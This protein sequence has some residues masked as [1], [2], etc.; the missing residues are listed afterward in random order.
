MSS[1]T[2]EPTPDDAADDKAAGSGDF[3][4]RLGIFARTFRRSTPHEVAREVTAA[5]FAVAHWNFAAIGLCR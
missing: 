1:T 5:G 2:R 4:G 3:A